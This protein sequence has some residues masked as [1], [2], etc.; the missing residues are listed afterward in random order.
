MFQRNASDQTR[1]GTC[2][3]TDA[4]LKI[5]AEVP[6]LTAI[7]LGMGCE[8]TDQGM[9]TLGTLSQLEELTIYRGEITDAGLAQ[10]KSCSR[11]KKLCLPRMQVVHR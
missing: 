2:I 7:N 10:L 3:I 9:A 8:V 4:E 5:L 6:T 1:P 11:L